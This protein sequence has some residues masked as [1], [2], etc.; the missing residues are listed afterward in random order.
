MIENKVIDKSPMML[1]PV[2]MV[3]QSH[4]V[5]TPKTPQTE[6]NESE[7]RLE[8]L[9]MDLLVIIISNEPISMCVAGFACKAISFNYT[10]PDRSRQEMLRTMTPRP[11]EH[12]P[13]MGGKKDGKAVFMP[14]PH[15]PKAQD[16]VS[17]HLLASKSLR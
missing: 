6:E 12:W 7:S 10:T 8:C 5:R 14:S 4:L 16:M 1:S 3:K 13:F 9:P 17:G 11:T 15:T 2:D